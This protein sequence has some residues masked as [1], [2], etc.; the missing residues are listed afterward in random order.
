MKFHNKNK[1]KKPLLRLLPKSQSINLAGEKKLEK[2]KREFTDM[3][4]LIK[5]QLVDSWSEFCLNTV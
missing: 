1:K 3:E 4:T 2:K 5:G